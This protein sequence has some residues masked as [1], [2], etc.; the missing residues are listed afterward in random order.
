MLTEFTSFIAISFLKL[1]VG[2]RAYLQRK[3]ILL[4]KQ[5]GHMSSRKNKNKQE[6]VKKYYVKGMQV[7]TVN[8]KKYNLKLLNIMLVF[9]TVTV[10][11]KFFCINYT[12]KFE[13]LF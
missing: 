4:R 6:I 7:I 3:K 9:K 10:A 2:K 12:F 11:F 13:K 1:I 8:F 5:R